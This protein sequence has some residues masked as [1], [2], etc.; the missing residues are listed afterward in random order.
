VSVVLAV[1]AVTI[2]PRIILY[3]LA[4]FVSIV[5]VNIHVGATLYLSRVFVL[6][7][8]ASLLV[9]TAL[10]A[11][12]QVSPRLL[13]PFVLIF[14]LMLFFQLVAAFT[15]P[16]VADGVR[17][18]FI[19]VSAMLIFFA[20]IIV[21][22]TQEAVV[23]AVYIYLAAGIFQ[24]LY[25]MY[26]V[27]GAPFAWP[28]Y[29]TFMAGI[30]TANDR[31]DDG[32][33]YAGAYEAFRA[34]GFFSA[35]V[36]HYAGFMAGIIVLAVALIV[37]NRRA[38]FPYIAAIFGAAGLIFSLSRSGMVACVVFGFPSLFFVLSRIRPL[39]KVIYQSIVIPGAI[40]AVLALTLGHFILTSYGIELPNMWEIIST[41][42][43]D[44]LTP[45][46]NSTESM[47]E[48]LATRIA[49]LKAFASSPVLGVGLGVNEMP[50]FETYA[51]RGWG[52]SH[53]HHLD[54]LG[55]TGL[56]GLSLQFLFMGIVGA[57]MW[58]GFSITRD[59]SRERYVLGGL[60]ANYLAIFFGNFLY[61]YFMQDFVWF[62]MGAGV[63][64]SRLRILEATRK[65]RTV[66][67]SPAAPSAQTARSLP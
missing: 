49:G 48:H 52:G 58:R 47:G 14:A 4:A 1:A 53:S 56:V 30:P 26:Q 57:Y 31:T 22:D 61:A 33:L 43:A 27:V 38:I 41:R 15:S 21:A 11:R 6:L 9:K 23:R 63:A 2:R 34:T 35:D 50:W 36:S 65:G 17:V 67:P 54:V 45:G 7:F 16:Q 3:G 64:L 37:Y 55:Q 29:Q 46:S 59:Q 25:G 28:T 18:V 42:F 44:L 62:I 10:G 19:Y 66:A 40:G 12:V 8:L 39:G 24:A 13:G 60:L 51:E 5:G 32:F 20:V